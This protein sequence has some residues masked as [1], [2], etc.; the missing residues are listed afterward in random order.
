M[1]FKNIEIIKLDSPIYKR[2]A[3]VVAIIQLE[4]DKNFDA[5]EVIRKISINPRMFVPCLTSKEYI[6]MFEDIV[7]FHNKNKIRFNTSI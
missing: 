1:K 5:N 7:N 4:R 2:R 3:F 6:S